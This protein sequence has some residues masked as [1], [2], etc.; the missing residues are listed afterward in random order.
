MILWTGYRATAGI[1]LG[2]MSL[3]M[4]LLSRAGVQTT[5]PA[6]I[7]NTVLMGVG[8]MALTACLILVQNA[9][10]KSQRGVVTSTQG[11]FRTVGSAIGVTIMGMVL[12]DRIENQV[13]RSLKS[14][15][16]GE[17]P[18][19]LAEKLMDPRALLDA[20]L[21]AQLPQPV[22]EALRMA[23]ADSLHQVFLL[24]L[25]ITVLALVASFLLPGGRAG[26]YVAE[27]ESPIA[28]G[29]K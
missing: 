26:D 15:T 3:G 17:T 2:L 8:G 21:R 29:R 9:V 14:M 19:A 6:M 1:A 10:G 24:C 12:N 22:A 7:P 27:K 11:F 16:W 13:N 18:Q 20:S 25:G 23:L 4:F 5:Y 28:T